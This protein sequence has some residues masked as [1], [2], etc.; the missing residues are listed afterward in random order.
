MSILRKVGLLL[1]SFLLRS[2]LFFGFTLLAVVLVVGN[3][4]NVKDSLLEVNTYERFTQSVLDTSLDKSNEDP[5]SIPLDDP[6]I[7]EIIKLSLN[8]TDLQKIAESGIDAS[9]DWLEGNQENI[10]FSVD[11]SK[12]K[13]ILAGQSA[14][15]AIKRLNNLDFCLTNPEEIN[16]FRLPCRPNYINNAELRQEIYN[17]L[18]SDESIFKAGKVSDQ[19][20]P[21]ISNEQRVEE[22]Y[23]KLP[24]YFSLAKIAP[25]AIFVISIMAMIG[26]ILL[27]KTKLLGLKNIA[28]SLMGTAFV[29]A[30]IPLLYLFIFPLLGLSLPSFNNS[31]QAE[32]LA[33][34]SNDLFDNIYIQINN[35]LL[36]IALQVATAGIV[37]YFLARYLRPR[38]QDYATLERK[39]GISSSFKRTSGNTNKTKSKPPIQTSEKPSKA[40]H[41]EQTLEKK[42]KKLW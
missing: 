42:F 13:E 16:V 33:E 27:S 9:Y 29:L 3:R 39:S 5:N 28:V 7:A 35:V 23:P 30:V 8:E 34:I 10:K 26:I 40:K 20:L 17:T 14:D 32:S 11:V 31:G 1:V 25:Y 15:Y 12:N 19:D 21:K 37:L 41:K 2:S 38:F 18:I 36:N 22:A 24:D 4:D 6:K